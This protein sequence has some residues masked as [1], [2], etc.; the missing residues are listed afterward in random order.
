M[1]SLK[2]NF[3]ADILGKPTTFVVEV[4][5]HDGIV[6][7]SEFC[8]TELLEGSVDLMAA[9]RGESLDKFMADCRRQLL[10][11]SRM[12]DT[13]SKMERHIGALMAVVMDHFSRV[14]RMSFG[15]LLMHVDCFSLLLKAD[16][17]DSEEI[18]RIYPSVTKT[19]VELYSD[20]VDG[21]P[22]YFTSKEKA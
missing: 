6:A 9:V 2:L 19:V 12:D 16:G 5:Y 3:D 17:V 4:P 10:A 15:D 18:C 22:E 7:T 1:E 20:Y 21:V 8:P 11:M 13:C 14:K